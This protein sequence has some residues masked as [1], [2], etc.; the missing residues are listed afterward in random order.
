MFDRSVFSKLATPSVTLTLSLGDFSQDFQLCFD[1][2]AAALVKKELGKSVFSRQEMQNLDFSEWRVVV[3][4]GLHRHQKGITV[5]DVGSVMNLGNMQTIIET[6][7]KAFTV[8]LKK[9][10]DDPT[11]E[12]PTEPVAAQ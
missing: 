6:C 4:A 10:A 5:E 9:T 1:M 3:W 7:T 2:N 8:G 12:L 11:T